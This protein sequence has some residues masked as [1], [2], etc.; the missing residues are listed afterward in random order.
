[1]PVRYFALVYGIV[2]LLI[3]IAGFIP[4]LVTSPQG[5]ADVEV[6]AGF[7]RLFGLFPINWLHNLVHAAF[8]IWGL[9]AY[10][11]FS[12]AR[13]YAQ[14]VAVIYAVFVVM[15]FI[16]VLQTTFG[17]VPLYGHNIWLHAG[18]AIVAAYFGF[19]PARSV[20]GPA[21]AASQRP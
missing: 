4:G 3:G 17:L 19:A 1:M 15:G 16:P 2:F 6:E 8:G 13:I 11:S 7:G 20:G 5:G 21:T 9:A 14:S 10:R 12:R 18:L